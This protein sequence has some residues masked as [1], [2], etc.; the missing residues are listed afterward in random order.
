MKAET[1]GRVE[2]EKL[3]SFGESADKG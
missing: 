1:V 2:M 3:T